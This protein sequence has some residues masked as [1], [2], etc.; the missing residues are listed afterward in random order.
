MCDL[1][2]VPGV[3]DGKRPLALEHESLGEWTRLAFTRFGVDVDV[4]A[5]P[6]PVDRRQQE[7]HVRPYAHPN[8]LG[9][10]V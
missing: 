6:L 8:T 10:C 7:I 4:S 1:R 9:I 2:Q 3:G 5:H